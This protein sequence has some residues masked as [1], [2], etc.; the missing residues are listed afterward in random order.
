[1]TRRFAGEG[2]PDNF[3]KD[4]VGKDDKVNALSEYYNSLQ[5]S[6]T[7]GKN[8]DLFNGK[9][10]GYVCYQT[11]PSLKLG[12]HVVYG[13]NAQYPVVK[14]ADIYVSL[15]GYNEGHGSYPWEEIPIIE[16]DFKITDM[17]APSNPQ[18]FKKMIQW[19]VEQLNTG[20][21][22]HVGC[23]GGHGRTGVVLSAMAA[24]MGIEDATNY[25]RT[26]YCKKAVESK[27][28]VD[29]LAKHFGIKPVA[30]TKDSYVHSPS[31][32][33]HKKGSKDIEWEPIHTSEYYHSPE[34]KTVENALVLDATSS[35]EIVFPETVTKAK[36]GKSGRKV[37]PIPSARNIWNV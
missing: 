2:F 16:I 35:G 34:Q 18:Q 28:Q 7:K 10:G 33:K 22:I 6:S 32:G 8:G 25:V 36:A 9:T 11:H 20:K 3:Y 15:T 29:F 21:K 27:E 5:V 1:M 31:K 4:Y 19:L 12:T 24:V 26:H 37:F 23:Q 13:G 14:D 17:C 30:P